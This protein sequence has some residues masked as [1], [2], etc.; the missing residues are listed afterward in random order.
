MAH[1]NGFQMANSDKPLAL[2][3]SHIL[4][5]HKRPQLGRVSHSASKI[6][7]IDLGGYVDETAPAPSDLVRQIS[8][9]CEHYGFFHIINHGVPD[10]LCDR[11][12]NELTLMFQLPHQERAR[13]ISEDPSK[14]VKILN[15]SVPVDDAAPH[16]KVSMWSECANH[17]WHPT[18]DFTSQFPECLRSYGEVVREF[19][20][21]LGALADRLLSL[22]SQGLGLKND[23]LKRRFE[24][25]PSRK[26]HANYYPPCPDP[27]LTLGLRAHKDP[28]ALNMLIQSM[29]ASGLQVMKDGEWIAIDPLPNALVINLGDQLQLLSNGRY[30][31]TVHRAINNKDARVSLAMFYGLLSAVADPIEDLVEV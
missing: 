28:I 16:D 29:G 23:R 9:A 14:G 10:E 4:P 13:L 7:V 11:V 3:P 15:Y 22:M 25:E 26:A 5:E 8:H 20:K 18:Y 17:I 21:E 30:K 31:S 2:N 24:E 12:L 19:S 1:L 27:D 6:P